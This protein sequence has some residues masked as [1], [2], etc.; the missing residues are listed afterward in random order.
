MLN[1]KVVPAL[2]FTLLLCACGEG[3]KEE[4]HWS[5]SGETGPEH[6]NEIEKSA[7]CNGTRQSPINIIDVDVKADSELLSLDF[8]Y[9][10]TTKIHN[11]TNNGHSIQFNFE[12]GDYLAVED[13]KFELLQIHFHEPAEHTINGIRYPI[14][15]HF[16]HIN[17]EN[18]DLMVLSMMGM[19]GRN[20]AFFSFLEGYLPVEMGQTKAVDTPFDLLSGLPE[21]HD[22]YHYEG[23][24]TT[25]PCT[26]NVSWYVL[27]TPITLAVDQVKQLQALMPLNNYRTE[28]P[29]N[30]RTVSQMPIS[31]T[32]Q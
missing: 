24:L 31:S 32:S 8:H 10:E 23:S 22:Y 4:S 14:E 27:K 21:S 12:K 19:E 29:L 5:Y 6:W 30:A 17:P 3:S 18:K 25:P 9:S 28:Q 26:E 7:D 13:E 11:L 15:V 20:N 2:L 16:V 1:K